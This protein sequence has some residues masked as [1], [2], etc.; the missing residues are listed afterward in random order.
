MTNAVM[1]IDGA[2]G[3]LR[4]WHPPDRR[5]GRAPLHRRGLWLR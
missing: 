3:K 1:N 4:R 2:V 5:A